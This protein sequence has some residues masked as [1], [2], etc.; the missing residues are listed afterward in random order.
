MSDT[1][2][3]SILQLLRISYLLLENKGSRLEVQSSGIQIRIVWI[4]RVYSVPVYYFQHYS[5]NSDLAFEYE[6]DSR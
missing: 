2:K 5:L 4:L 6:D 1:R 3:L